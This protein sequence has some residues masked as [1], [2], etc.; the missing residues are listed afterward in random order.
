[1]ARSEYTVLVFLPFVW[2]FRHVNMQPPLSTSSTKRPLMWPT[3]LDQKHFV[4]AFND[5]KPAGYAT[6]KN[7][8]YALKLKIDT[9]KINWGI[10]YFIRSFSENLSSIRPEIDFL[11]SNKVLEKKTECTVLDLAFEPFLAGSPN[12]NI[13]IQLPSLSNINDLTHA[14]SLKYPRSQK[15]YPTP[16]KH[17]R[18]QKKKVYLTPLKHRR[19]K[20]SSRQNSHV[21]NYK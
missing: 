10:K 19:S 1:M 6:P 8:N 18:S 5:P 15:K 4:I 17:P 16:L 3:F 12:R 11:K 20:T 14:T 7:W 21:K 9:P 13:R 2:F